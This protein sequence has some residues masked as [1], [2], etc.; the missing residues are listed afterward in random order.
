[1]NNPNS[2]V[3][4]LQRTIPKGFY[5]ELAFVFQDSKVVLIR[6]NKTTKLGDQ[7]DRS[8]RRANESKTQ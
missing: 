6:E 2:V 8:D 5:G 3:E 7:N 4:L 1:M